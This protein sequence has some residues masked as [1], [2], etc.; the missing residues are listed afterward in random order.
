MARNRRKKA[1]YE[2][3]SKARLKPG[4]SRTLDQVRPRESY[5]RKL[6]SDR[7][8]A[9]EMPKDTAQWWKKRRIVQLNASRIEFSIPY[10]LAVL[11]LLGLILLVLAAYRFGQFSYPTGQ[12]E[13]TEPAGETPNVDQANPAVDRAMIET[14]RPSAS[15]TDVPLNTEEVEPSESTGQNVIVLVE[16]GTLSQLVPVREHFARNGIETEIVMENGRYLLQTEDRYG[17]PAMPGTDGYK[18]KQRITEVGAKY[19]A[20]AG[21]ETFA[22]NFFSDAYGKKVE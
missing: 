1:F 7:K 8:P 13:A 10:Q 22:P 6:T 9:V 4:Y 21:H 17:N 14:V 11:L 2:V 15:A 12:R 20:P 19:R 16:Y 5:E 18:A 3:M